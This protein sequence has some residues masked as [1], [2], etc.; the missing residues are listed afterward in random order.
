MNYTFDQFKQ[1]LFE[2]REVEF[3]YKGDD[4]SITKT[5][6]GICFCKFYED[7]ICFPNPQELINNVKIE[8]KSLEVIFSLNEFE[9]ETL[10]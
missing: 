2:G 5:K 1:D 9:L 4:F 10:F 3:K 6:N 8:G 7:D